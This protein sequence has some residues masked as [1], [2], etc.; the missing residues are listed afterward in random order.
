M[1]VIARVVFG[2]FLACLAAGL[3]TVLFAWS[4]SELASMPGDPLEKIALALPLATHVAIFSAPFALIA[5]ALGEWQ[6]SKNWVYYGLAGMVIA[7]IG[8]IAQYQSEPP[9]Q[10]WS[11]VGSNYPLAAVLTTG[12]VAGLVYWLFSGQ[13]VNGHN[14]DTRHAAH[15][16][17]K[18]GGNAH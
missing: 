8:F 14:L 7:M 18:A 6:K 15:H 12:L 1:G 9:T 2:F 4:P 3:T 5:I 10:C 16:A 17:A 11:V 13:F